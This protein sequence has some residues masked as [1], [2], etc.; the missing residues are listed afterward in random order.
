MLKK[1]LVPLD[2][3]ALAENA[4]GYAAELSVPTGAKLMLARVA[5]SHTLAGVDPRER[6]QG[7]V[8][9]AEEY[10]A[11][12]AAALVARGYACETCVPYGHAAESIV[13][14]AR[15]N[16]VDLIVMTT[17]GRT[18]PGRV[19]FGSVA[20]SVVASATV[21]VLVTRAWLPPQRLP[22]L[23][24]QPVFIVPLD[25]SAFAESAIEPAVGLADDVGAA[26]LLMRG[27]EAHTLESDALDYL[28]SVDAR[29]ADQYPDLTVLTEVR[30]GNPAQ[31][32]EDAFRQN[33]ASLVF[34][35]T[36]GH[37]GI[38]RSITGSVAGEVIKDG[39]APV[40]LIRPVAHS[41]A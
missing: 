26:V 1:I 37:G 18:G 6:Q 30:T 20:E 38:V 12:T 15:L 4:V 29:L 24:D 8:A 9:E 23:A 16:R 22:F 34:M 41:L 11:Q 19:L 32:I 40:V 21:P 25:G 5:Y 27:V 3:S 33:G 28:Q 14:Q 31:T 7:A 13:E 35:A 10:L 39:C 36:H 17:H 2:G